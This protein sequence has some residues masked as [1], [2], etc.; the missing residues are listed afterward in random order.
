MHRDAQEILSGLTGHS[1]RTLTGR[2]NTVLRLDEDSVLVA[3][4]RSPAG[5]PVPIQEVQVALDLLRQNSEIIINPQTVGYRSAFV[6][7]RSGDAA[8]CDRLDVRPGD[9]A[10]PAR[11]TG[12][13]HHGWLCSTDS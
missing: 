12:R 11:A 9:P 8:R 2:S 7:R 4:E 3:A 5:E 1:I 13:R 6:R 10:V